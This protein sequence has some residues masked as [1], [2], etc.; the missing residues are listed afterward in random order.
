MGRI[1]QARRRLGLSQ[2]ELAEASGVSAATI[3]QVELGNR[4]PQGRTLR[5]LAGALSVEVADLF[6]EESEA[7]PKAPR[8]SPLEPKLFN[9]RDDERRAL[10]DTWGSLLRHVGGQ[11]Q[12]LEGKYDPNGENSDE[13]MSL[14]YFT[15]KAYRASDPKAG[16]P[17]ELVKHLEDSESVL[18][19]G[20]EMVM[21]RA[22]E[23]GASVTQ[24]DEYREKGREALGTLEGTGTA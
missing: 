19:T 22:S 2:E 15:I 1:R 11:L 13:L 12:D 24:L 6:E 10:V 18:R 4:R 16:A 20:I 21:Q 23:S 7:H 5:K 9:G 14:A 3:V 17:A 8:R